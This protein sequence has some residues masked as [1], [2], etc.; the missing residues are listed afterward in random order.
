MG[1]TT[2]GLY[3]ENLRKSRKIKRVLGLGKLGNAKVSR[4]SNPERA[5][6]VE[7]L[8]KSKPPFFDSFF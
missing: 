5:K 3:V 4:L 2:S 6:L 1:N 7:E 8:K